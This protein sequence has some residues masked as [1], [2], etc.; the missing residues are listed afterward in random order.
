MTETL[1]L[2]R[3]FLRVDWRVLQK[4]PHLMNVE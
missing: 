4:E 1:M 2:Q 3:T